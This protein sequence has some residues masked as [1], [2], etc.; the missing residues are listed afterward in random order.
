MS[1]PIYTLPPF[2]LQLAA[3]PLAETFDWW[4]TELG[5]PEIHKTYRGNGVKVAILDT[6]CDTNHGDLSGAIADAI[7]LTGSP[8]GVRDAVSHGTWVACAL[9]ARIN[10]VGGAGVLPEGQGYIAKV[11]GDNGSGS[12][13][14]IV[15]GIEWAIAKRVD[16]INMSLGSPSD[17]PALRAACQRAESAGIR[18]V[19]AAGNDGVRS[20]PNFPGA[21]P[22]TVAVGAVNR[23][24]ELAPFSSRG[25]YVDIVTFG[26]DMLAGINGGGYGRMSGSS[27]AS[28]IAA[29]VA[30]LLIEMHRRTPNHKTPITNVQQLI[31][32]LK[33]GARDA[34]PPGRDVGYG[35]GV[36]NPRTILE[37]EAPPVQ[38]PPA[39]E[40]GQP[41]PRA[42]I[43]INLGMGLVFHVPAQPG[44]IVTGGLGLKLGEPLDSRLDGELLLRQLQQAAELELCLEEHPAE[45]CVDWL[46]TWP[47][48]HSNEEEGEATP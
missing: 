43:E 33:R 27:M 38:S 24:G 4:Y 28:P 8:I 10:N 46:E 48:D 32:H 45:E 7:D 3:T 29:G 14:S 11:L 21:L 25:P 42:A 39:P 2:T 40:P 15:N 6:G 19:C 36:I 22:T 16:V 20:R 34:G 31:E 12:I 1:D 41:V 18:V 13:R 5:F 23:A 26:V 35:W 47:G 30:G 17:D 9:L 44:D 37:P